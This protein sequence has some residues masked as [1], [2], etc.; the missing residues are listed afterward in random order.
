M[1]KW[2]LYFTDRAERDLSQLSGKIQKRIIDKI[3]W[4]LGNF[5]N[6]DPIALKSKWQGFFKLRVGDWRI[7]YKID[8]DKNLIIIWIID[9]RDKIYKRK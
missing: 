5:T 3:D 9:R 7:I 8:H 2:A 1:D 4:L 6:I